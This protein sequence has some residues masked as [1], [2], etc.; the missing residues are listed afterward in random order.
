MD[1]VVFCPSMES[2]E[3]AELIAKEWSLPIQVGDSERTS[4][5]EFD[6]NKVGVILIPIYSGFLPFPP[7]IKPMTSISFNYCDDFVDCSKL[8]FFLSMNNLLID[9]IIKMN[10]INHD[11]H[12][13][14]LPAF[15]E[16]EG[17]YSISVFLES[18]K[19]TEVNFVVSN[20]DESEIGSYA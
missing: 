3:E 2:I 1:R 14:A 8:D 11:L 5:M 20:G 16:S 18:I 15:F 17:Y 19:I 13:C 6:R 12:H 9:K 7:V 4:G 10:A